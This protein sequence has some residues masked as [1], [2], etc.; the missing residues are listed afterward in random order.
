LEGGAAA[1]VA[2]AVTRRGA[3]TLPHSS[4]EVSLQSQP[5][6]PAMSSFGP[7]HVAELAFVT[8]AADILLAD[9]EP[10]AAT[11]SI[12]STKSPASCPDH[13]IYQ[14]SAT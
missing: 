5:Q 3:A 10:T 12:Q 4:A 2:N 1:S 13:S 8:E 6:D 14:T 9:A 7:N 11:G